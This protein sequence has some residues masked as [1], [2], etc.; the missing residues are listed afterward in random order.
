MGNS[1]CDGVKCLCLE[2]SL[3][4]KKF[5]SSSTQS[6]SAMKFTVCPFTKYIWRM[7]R[8]SMIKSRGE[9]EGLLS[10]IHCAQTK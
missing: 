2:L 4:C 6:L 3:S 5:P 1:G 7:I 9:G 10:I 8:E